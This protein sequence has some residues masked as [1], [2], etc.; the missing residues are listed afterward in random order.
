MEDNIISIGL[1]YFQ[2]K[3][4]DLALNYFEQ[5]LVTNQNNTYC[6][7]NKGFILQNQIE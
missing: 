4:Y 3:Q 6:L 2:N 1:N 5:I 7:L